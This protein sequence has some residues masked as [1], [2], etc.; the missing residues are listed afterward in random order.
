LRRPEDGRF[1]VL[2]RRFA[3]LT[4]E[5]PFAVA[6]HRAFPEPGFSEE[7]EPIAET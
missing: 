1:V 7:R 3:L 2:D 6:M 4:G 5:R